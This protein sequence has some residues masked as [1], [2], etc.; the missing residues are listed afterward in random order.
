MKSSTSE[1]RRPAIL[2][3]LISASD[4]M[5]IDI[6]NLPLT[7]CSGYNYRLSR[8]LVRSIDCSS[9]REE[10]SVIAEASSVQ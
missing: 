5:T 3:A 6:G 2:I 10:Q 9:L 4:L 7:G 1:A 8:K